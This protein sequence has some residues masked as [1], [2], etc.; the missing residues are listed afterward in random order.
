MQKSQGVCV[1]KARVCFYTAEQQWPTRG[2]EGAATLTPVPRPSMSQ[3]QCYLQVKELLY[4][5]SLFLVHKKEADENRRC[6][7]V[8]ESGW[9]RMRACGRRTENHRRAGKNEMEAQGSLS[10]SVHT[11]V[12]GEMEILSLLLGFLTFPIKYSLLRVCI[13]DNSRANSL[14]ISVSL[15]ILS[16]CFQQ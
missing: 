7:P 16:F 4:L 12:D 6:W 9:Q 14:G 13:R 3:P 1:L 2:S 15:W 10:L 8:M 5:I 11:S